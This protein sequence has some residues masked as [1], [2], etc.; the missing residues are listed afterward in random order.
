[1]NYADYIHNAERCLEDFKDAATRPEFAGLDLPQR[2]AAS[3]I[4]NGEAL[5]WA[6]LAVACKPNELV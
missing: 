2:Y 4:A 5:V 1:M 3:I 6:T